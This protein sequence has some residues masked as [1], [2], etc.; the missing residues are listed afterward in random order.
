MVCPYEDYSTQTLY[1][2]S[3][4]LVEIYKHLNLITSNKQEYK[5]LYHLI[6]KAMV[7]LS[8]NFDWC[9]AS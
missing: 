7:K 8:F 6:Y 4:R 5:L 1:Q 3:E 2:S 9:V